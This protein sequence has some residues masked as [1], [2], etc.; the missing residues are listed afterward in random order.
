MTFISIAT[1]MGVTL[2]SA[3]RPY[4]KRA[5]HNIAANLF[6]KPSQWRVGIYDPVNA[7]GLDYCSESNLF[8]YEP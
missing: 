8:S 5:G 3:A 6:T 2:A 4:Q 7:I 1:A